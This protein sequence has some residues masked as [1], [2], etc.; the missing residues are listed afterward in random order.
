MSVGL[1][2]ATALLA[3]AVAGACTDDLGVGGDNSG[4]AFEIS[5]GSGTQPQYSWPGGTA[6]SVTVF[7]SGETFPIWGVSSPSL[8]NI[9]S[10]YQH[11]TQPTGASIVFDDQPTLIPGVRYRVEIVLANNQEAFREFRP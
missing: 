3:L 5:I 6:L 8:R 10:P 7:E 2:F 4:G 1:K 11:G 9:S